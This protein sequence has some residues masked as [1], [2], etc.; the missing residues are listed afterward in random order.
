[1]YLSRD[2][3]RGFA[4]SKV[5]KDFLDSV[6]SLDFDRKGETLVVSSDDETIRVFN[7]ITGSQS[8]VVQSKKYGVDNIRVAPSEDGS[9]V[10]CSSRNGSW[11]DTLRY[12]SLHTNRFLRY[13]KGH[14][15]KV[16][17]LAMSP[18][19][20]TFASASQ[21]ETVR[22]WDLRVS[23]CQG[24]LRVNPASSQGAASSTI[25]P[26]VAFDDQG[27]VMGVV[28]G[29]TVRLY[30]CKMIDSPPFLSARIDTPSG[31]AGDWRHVKFSPCGRYI[32]LGGAGEGGA[33]ITVIDSF[34]LE[35]KATL[36]GHRAAAS[37]EPAWTPDGNFVLCGSD[38]GTVHVWEV[39]TGEM[40]TQ[41]TGHS[42]T[43][44]AVG[45]NPRYMM[46]ACCCQH[47][48]LW[49]NEGGY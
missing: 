49:T 7:C 43:V 33:I 13:F 47:V 26:G 8:K 39:A 25:S 19:N 27:V 22:L 6:N 21:D 46:A 35:V 4:S 40:V 45:F 2:S 18:L 23:A 12:L 20:D 37:L 17:G 30:D 11:D 1:M 38:T 41:W 36:T 14:R 10:I 9:A 15:G 32:L 48:C 16:T 29:P 44:R 5:H 31:R 34:S 28:V 3:L 42:G 24:L